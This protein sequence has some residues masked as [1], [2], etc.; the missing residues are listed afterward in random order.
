VTTTSLSP[1]TPLDVATFSEMSSDDTSRSCNRFSID[2]GTSC[3]ACGTRGGAAEEAWCGV[4]A[5]CRSEEDPVMGL[6][7]FVEVRMVDSM[8]WFSENS[9]RGGGLPYPDRKS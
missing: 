1:D 8:G 9:V 6:K 4:A 2:G 7:T 3:S 5:I